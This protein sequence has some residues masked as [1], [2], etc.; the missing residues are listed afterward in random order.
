MQEEEEDVRMEF[1]RLYGELVN[2]EKRNALIQ[3]DVLEVIKSGRTPLIITE[4]KEH[5]DV[6][7]GLLQEADAT[8]VRLQGGMR[9]SAQ[10]EAMDVLKESKNNERSLI[11]LATGK[12]IGEGFDDS[13]FDTLF[14]TLPV[15]WKGTVAQYVGRLHRVYEGKRDVHVYDYADLDVPMLSRMFD[16]R[17]AGYEEVGYTIL[18]PASALPGWP[19]SVPLT[20][21]PEWKRTYAASIQR[22]VTD[23]V[24]VRLAQLFCE[25]VAESSTIHRELEGHEGVSRSASER[26]FYERLQSLPETKN[27]FRM[28]VELSVPF[29]QRSGM[30][31]DFLDEAIRLVIEIDGGQHLSDEDAYR[32]DRR[33][34]AL[35][36]EHG[37]FVLR[38]LATDLALRL[39]RVL[40][41]VIRTVDHLKSRD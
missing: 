10:R 17:C 2:S 6:I 22:L 9:N 30:E 28:N 36:Q 8:L 1:Q 14:L 16:R 39:D 25:S 21:N 32:S 33:K 7:E 19:A 34:D 13:R 11:L 37:Y 31:V 4:R 26:F 27:R 41:Q 15:S 5:L 18:L 29:N 38:F 40:D 20:I 24:D 23:G 35:L 3:A 12:L